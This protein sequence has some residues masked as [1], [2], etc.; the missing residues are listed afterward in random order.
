[1]ENVNEKT[2]VNPYD[3][4]P[5]LETES[6]E[7]RLV[8]KSDAADLLVCYSD[9]KAWEIFNADYCTSDF[10][11]T[12]RKQMEECIDFWLEAYA[13]KG[14]VRFSILDKKSEKAV[15]TA[16]MFGSLNIEKTE[17]YGVLRIDIASGYETEGYLA[18]LIKLADGE[19]Y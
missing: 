17:D 1:M 10:R 14:F 18:E 6:F 2:W 12:A 9:E 19:F 7:L 15:G 16:E 3:E 4:C 8:E 5:V 11:Y 13:V